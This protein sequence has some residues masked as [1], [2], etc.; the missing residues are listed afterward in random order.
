MHNLVGKRVNEAGRLCLLGLVLLPTLKT[1]AK[2]AIDRNMRLFL[3]A[4]SNKND[5]LV[6]LRPSFDGKI[7]E[8]LS[9]V[10]KSWR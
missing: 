9:W 2:A 6:V 4:F 3:T 1:S 8:L 5:D 7:L 10:K